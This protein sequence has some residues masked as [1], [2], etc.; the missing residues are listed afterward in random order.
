M[1]NNER[2]APMPYWSFRQNNSGGVFHG[3][4]VNVVVKADDAAHANLI[5]SGISGVYFDGCEND[6][7]CPCCGDRWYRAGA[8]EKSGDKPSD[9]VY[10]PYDS[11]WDG[12]P[13]ALVYE[14]SSSAPVALTSFSD[15]D[16]S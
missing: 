10:S 9:T 14:S 13:Y 7:D 15:D 16:D 12:V 1:V 4:A 6:V 5:A 2:G 11:D 8:W 3:P